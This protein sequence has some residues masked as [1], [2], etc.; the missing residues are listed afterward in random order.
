MAL[1]QVQSTQYEVQSKTKYSVLGTM[2]LVDLFD[3]QLDI[4]NK[5]VRTV[6]SPDERFN[7]DAFRTMRAIRIAGELEFKIE[8]NTFEAIKEKCATDSKNCQGKS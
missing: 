8:E 2:Y 3:G 6:G 4:K 5:L 7:E 1:G